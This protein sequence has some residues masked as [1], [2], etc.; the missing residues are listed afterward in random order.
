MIESPFSITPNAVLDL[1]KKTRPFSDLDSGVLER[2]ASLW[3]VEFF[4]RGT[5]I[6]EKGSP[7][8]KRLYLVQK[9]AIKR[10]DAH[11][12]HEILVDMSGEGYAFDAKSII[13]RRKPD[14]TVE[15]IEN[16]FC[17]L[18]QRQDFLNLVNSCP[19]VA[20]YYLDAFSNEII[21]VAHHELRSE[22]IR[23]GKQESFFILNQRL[24]D[25]I[26]SFPDTISSA[27]TIRDA[28]SR[29]AVVDSNCLLI[30][31]PSQNIVGI[32]TDQDIR[33]KVVALGVEPSANVRVA[34]T[35][36]IP[37][38]NRNR[39]CFDALLEIVT[40]DADHLAVE[41]SGRI[42]GVM[43]AGEIPAAQGVSPLFLSRQ[44]S[45]QR[46]FEGL[47]EISRKIPLV[48]RSLI[49]GG[50]KASDVGSM[51]TSLKDRILHRFLELTQMS[52]GRAP[53]PFSWMTLGQDGRCEQDLETEHHHALMYSD[54]QDEEAARIA[55]EYFAQMTEIP[56]GPIFE[57]RRLHHAE[58][59]RRVDHRWRKDCSTWRR[60]FDEL[61]AAPGLR[62]AAS[63]PDLF[64]FRV[65]CGDCDLGE[66]LRRHMLGV[67][68]KR[69]DL[70]QRLFDDLLTNQP[71]LSFFRDQVVEKTGEKRPGLRLKFRGIKPIVDFARILAL[72]YGV[73]QTNT[74]A[75]LR[76]LSESGILQSGLFRD[77][78]EAYEFQMQ[79]I[80]IHQL[81][82]LESGADPDDFIFTADLPELERHMLKEIF[83]VISDVPAIMRSAK[84][85]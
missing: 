55:D 51:I 71:P 42:V 31:D 25:L 17:F 41:D 38:I 69:H 20:H 23:A 72:K 64:D 67:V 30:E 24:Q 27:S 12:G 53:I 58:H 59:G 81:E 14:F 16:T 68:R 62:R 33:S 1:L 52:I 11:K 10:Y 82:K 5:I 2:L 78:K 9:G 21:R 29:M 66:S 60:Y 74:L 26:L 45:N 13:K 49:E 80:L 77:I 15:A 76:S 44:V 22:K 34:M 56:I 63:N 32:I 6:L 70:F 46:D 65:T 37:A 48:I 50:A 47:R 54:P 73:K 35:N 43:S 4:P 36:P 28:A 8:P 19:E 57:H 40:E 79:M 39:T 75:R 7:E 3:V 83:R 84:W 61:M 18:L 85:L